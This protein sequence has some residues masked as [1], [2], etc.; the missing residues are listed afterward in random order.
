MSRGGPDRSVGQTRTSGGASVSFHA[1]D[2][3]T[4]FRHRTIWAARPELRDVYREWFQRLLTEVSGL[5]PAVE[6]GAG[7]GFFKE[8][9]PCLMATD[10]VP[11]DWIDVRCDAAALPF[12]AGSV[13]ALVMVDALHHLRRPLGFLQEAARVLR[14]GGRLAMLEPWI[15]PASF[16]LYRYIHHEDCRLGVDV[17]DPFGDAAKTAL[18]GNAAIPFL[19]VRQLRDGGGPLRLLTIETF[20]GLP[21]LVTLGFKRVRP[22]PSIL[23]RAARVAET[24]VRPLRRFLATRAF[25][26][27]EK[28]TVG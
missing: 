15:T 22:V 28:P 19:A 21:Y 26:V 25:I 10:V 5:E 17:A 9:A 14:P 4:L 18:A 8:Y 7:P 2:A 13:G 6:V 3:E 11:G 27:L 12:R 24:W 20:V 16:L 23:V 1:S